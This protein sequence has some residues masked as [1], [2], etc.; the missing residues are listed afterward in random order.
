MNE[1]ICEYVEQ[2]FKSLSENNP[3]IPD[4]VLADFKTVL[5]THY[6]GKGMVVDVESIPILHK[7]GGI[8]AKGHDYVIF[9]TTHQI[10]PFVELN[11]WDVSRGGLRH[12]ESSKS[13]FYVEAK[14][15]FNFLRKIN[16]I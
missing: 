4:S 11:A 2:A 15:L 9:D 12:S 10:M 6:S 1:K 14:S 13:Y 16:N 7:P 8:T 3:N 5:D